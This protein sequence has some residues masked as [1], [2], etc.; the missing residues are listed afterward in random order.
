MKFKVEESRR[1]GSVQVLTLS[2]RLVFG[3]GAE[4]LDAS[5]QNLIARGE[6]ALL[7]DCSGV[8]A[9]DSEGI[10]PLVRNAVS[11]HKRGGHL[12]LLK[13]SPHVRL[14]LEVTRLL[15]VIEAFDDE[16]AALHSF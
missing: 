10:C 14:V 9:I 11:L 4:A 6:R 16:Q 3:D 8:T 15:T 1:V 2:G 7:L 13:L 5:L 12:K